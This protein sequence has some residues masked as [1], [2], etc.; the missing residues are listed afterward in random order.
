MLKFL[1]KCS[2]IYRPTTTLI[3]TFIFIEIILQKNHATRNR[4]RPSRTM[5]QYD[6]I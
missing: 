5:W 2:K 3:Y 6:R 4:D 1:K